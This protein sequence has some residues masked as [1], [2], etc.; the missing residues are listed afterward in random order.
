MSRKTQHAITRALTLLV[1]VCLAACASPTNVAPTEVS[2]QSD[3]CAST[4]NTETQERSHKPEIAGAAIGGLAVAGA[5]GTAAL[6]F[7]PALGLAAVG[8]GAASGAA[9]GY[10][11]HP[12]P[13]Y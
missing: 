9:V 2:G 5:L 1:A 4:S 7:I 6:T 11:L 10:A 3:R 13:T 12:C 8:L